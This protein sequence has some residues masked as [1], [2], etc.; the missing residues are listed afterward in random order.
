MQYQSLSWLSVCVLINVNRVFFSSQTST[1][2]IS[3]KH[4]VLVMCIFHVSLKVVIVY[5]FYLAFSAKRLWFFMLY[6]MHFENIFR[7]ESS[8]ARFTLERIFLMTI[9]MSDEAIFMLTA[10]ITLTTNELDFV[11]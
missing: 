2:I 11:I 8:R 5:K 6:L 1:T 3:N 7:R 9:L 10:V 4:F